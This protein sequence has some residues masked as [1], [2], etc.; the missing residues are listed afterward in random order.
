M[1]AVAPYLA[2]VYGLIAGVFV[3][4][5]AGRWV[6]AIA[7]TLRQYRPDNAVEPPRRPLAW[8]LPLV[9]LLHSGP[10]VLAI[11]GYLSYYVLSRPHASWWLWFY[12]GVALSPLFVCGLILRMRR[13]RLQASSSDVTHSA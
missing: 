5:V 6:A 1:N 7:E 11:A 13:K 12:V 4:G 10:W 8:A 9:L 2:A 3:F